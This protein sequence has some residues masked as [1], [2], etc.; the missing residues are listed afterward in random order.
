MYLRT[1]KRKRTDGSVVEYFQ[2][3][4][5][6]RPTGG[7]S[8]VAKIIHNFGRTDQLD[9]NALTRLCLSIARVCGLSLNDDNET[10]KNSPGKVGL[11]TGV[12]LVG[13]KILGEVLVI[14]ELWE[15]L[16]IGRAIRKVERD[17]NLKIPH[18]RALFAMT[19]NRLCQPESKLGAYERWLPEVYLPS[20]DNLKQDHFYQAMDLFAKNA[21][22][23]EKSI[24]ETTADLFNLEVDLIFYDT[25]TASFSIDN[26]SDDDEDDLRKFGY[27]KEGGW[28]PQVVVALAVTREGFPVRS[29]VFPGN[30]SDLKTVEKV[31]S[32]LRGWKLG[33]AMFVADAGMNSKDNRKELARA[34][35]TY[36][37][38]S[39]IGGLS[40]VEEKVLSKR[41]R[42]MTIAENL[43]AKE[44]IVGN[45]ELR[46]RYFLCYNPK[47]AKRQ[48]L[49]RADVIAQIKSELASH[50]DHAAT[51][52]WAVDLL[53]SSRTRRYLRITKDGKIKLDQEA[54]KKAERLDGKW[55]MQTNDDTISINDAATGYK[56]LMVIERCFRTMKRAQINLMPVWHR[57]SQRIE[58][59]VKICVLAL[60]IERAA[61]HLTKK[62]WQ[63]M[64]PIFRR[65]QATRFKTDTHEFFEIN[66]IGPELRELLK[67]L[68]IPV[69]KRILELNPL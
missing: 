19:A 63:K 9:K 6:E 59:H 10:L 20:C 36:L 39:R 13:S 45:G 58:A 34:F 2:L 53:A 37:L 18:E 11:P 4:H 46:R 67:S 57:L 16:G 42:F 61:E 26:Q 33:R 41:G 69:P 38:S 7:G 48:R 56:S 64:H 35:G 54:V 22:E 62:S 21:S 30:T 29:W 31:K 17:S 24:F 55:V 27:P 47:E 40:E 66:E 14:E 8:P 28:A 49:H 50:K 23:V 65:L 12:K 60:L 15:R 43:H 52:R 68:K 3:A 51:A 25:T 32:D 44:V 5:N 1:T